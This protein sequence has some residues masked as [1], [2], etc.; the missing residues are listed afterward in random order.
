[1]R[2]TYVKRDAGACVECTA[3]VAQ[4]RFGALAISRPEH[5]VRLDAARCTAC[6]WCVDACGYRA[7]GLARCALEKAGAA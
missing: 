2:K 7:L 1:M 4:C 6:G 3:C 5:T